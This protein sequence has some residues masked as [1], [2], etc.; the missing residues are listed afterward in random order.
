LV[1]AYIRSLSDFKEFRLLSSISNS[2]HP[3]FFLFNSLVTFYK[4]NIGNFEL[5]AI[6]YFFGTPQ[7]VANSNFYHSRR[8][9]LYNKKPRSHRPYGKRGFVATTTT[10]PATAQR[11]RPKRL[12]FPSAI[13]KKTRPRTNGTTTHD[14]TSCWV[15]VPIEPPLTTREGLAKQGSGPAQQTL[16]VLV[17]LLYYCTIVIIHYTTLQI[18]KGKITQ[19]VQEKTT[20]TTTFSS[21]QYFLFDLFHNFNNPS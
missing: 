19:K 18:K 9:S 14:R 15:C 2:F 8:S 6:E 7:G 4:N 1:L 10:P 13:V 3:S 11:R 5:R 12:Y 16:S 20:T 21:H 17:L